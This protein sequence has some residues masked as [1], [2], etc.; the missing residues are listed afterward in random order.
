MTSMDSASSQR[1]ADTT[2][3]DHPRRWL[4]QTQMTDPH[5]YASMLSGMP[6]SIDGLCR[7]VQGALIHLEWAGAYGLEAHDLAHPSRDTLSL[8]DRLRRLADADP[9][10]L[11]VP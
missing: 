1:A 7:I 6:E 4:R 11:L 3:L 8:S 10:P 9:L 2:M 5:A